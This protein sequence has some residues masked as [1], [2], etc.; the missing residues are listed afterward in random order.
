[1]QR[2]KQYLQAEVNKANVASLNPPLDETRLVQELVAQYL[3]HEGYVETARAFA[4]EMNEDSMALA[5]RT[6]KSVKELGSTEDFDATNRQ[7]KLTFYA[8]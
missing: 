8:N 2:E 5:K 7:S 4:G 3:A 6:G 1:M